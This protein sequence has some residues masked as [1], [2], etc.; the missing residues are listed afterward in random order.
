MLILKPL[1]SN[2]YFP[3]HDD[4][5]VARVVVMGKALREGQFPVRWVSDLGYGYGYPIYNFYGPLPYYFG[6]SLY[7]LGV[8]SVVATKAMFAAGAI[9]AVIFFY[10]FVSSVFDPVVA[11]T[12]SILFAYSPYHAVQIYVRGAVGEYWAI[13]FIPL[14]LWGVLLASKKENRHVGTVVGAIGLSGVILS[15]TILGFVTTGITIVCLFFYF[16]ISLIRK[17]LTKWATVNLFLIP[18]LGLGVSAFFWIPAFFEMSATAVTTMIKTAPSG[19]FDHFVCPYQLWNSP[20]GFGGSAP[21]CIDGMSFKLGKVQLLS[22][23][24]GILLWIVLRRK[25]KLPDQ[26]I[27]MGIAA[28]IFFL[29]VFA[30]TDITKF[31]WTA[32]PFVSFIQYPWRLL[33]FTTLAM[34]MSGGYIVMVFRKI[35]IRLIVAAGVVSVCILMNAKL[36]QPQ[37]LYV[38]D[39]K[40][41]ETP[42]ELRYRISKI[43]DEYLP[44][45]IQ[46]PNGP[47]DFSRT[48]IDE[49]STLG[50]KMIRYTDTDWTASVQSKVNQ[51]IT[52]KTAFFPGWIY[53][54][55]GKTIVPAIAH[56]L[57]SMVVL[58]G[59]SVLIAHLTNTP[60]RTLGNILSLGS[61]I[62]L[63]SIIFY[64]KKT[65][66]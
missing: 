17:K 39:S 1:F 47:S 65:I 13:A 63:V 48:P 41:F 2:G 15:H 29:S 56:G 35:M 4:T 54:I 14:L 31:L 37:Y 50:V 26:S 53:Q 33:T 10:L 66:T 5:Q 62:V 38:R 23:F 46:K 19:F 18:V 28:G 22:S 36:F 30:V 45:G 40:A 42:E 20:W 32:V 43:S 64:G 11:M 49:S 21:G 44:S 51:T 34:G 7:A 57:P 3:M 16:L 52:L 12:G 60:V 24:L 25:N 61:V 27:F 58:E 59:K 9:L 8:D 55:N 6:G